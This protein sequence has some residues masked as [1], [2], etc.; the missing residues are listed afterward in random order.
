MSGTGEIRVND[1]GTRLLV[2]FT[3]CGTRFDFTAVTSLTSIS[4]LVVCLGPPMGAT[5]KTFAATFAASPSL[6]GTPF[7]GDG[8]DGWTE[9]TVVSSDVWDAQ[10]AW[11]LQGRVIFPGGDF[12]SQTQ[13]FQVFPNIC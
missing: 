8:S 10:G 2:Q 11:T 13:P 5:V 4:S 3:D 12:R 6:A 7:A 9:V 1:I